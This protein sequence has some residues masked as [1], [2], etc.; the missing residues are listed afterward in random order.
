MGALNAFEELVVL[1]LALGGFL[2][3]MMAKNLLAV[4]FL[5][6][7]I[8]SLVAILG[9]AKDGIMVLSL[10][11]CQCGPFVRVGRQNQPSS[12]W[13]LAGASWDLLAR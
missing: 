8:G 6:L 3:R 4:C 10:Q 5:D 13:R 11:N 1:R 7:F 12:L 9:Q 2:V